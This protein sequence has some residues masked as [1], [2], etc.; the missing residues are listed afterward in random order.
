MTVSRIVVGVDGSD[1]SQ[2]ALAW[3]I[4]LASALG[5]EIVAVHSVGLLTRDGHGDRVPASSHREEIAEQFERDWCAPLDAHTGPNRRVL[6]DGEPVDVVLSVADDV[7][8]DMIV[9]GSRGVG[10]YPEQLLGSTSHQVAERSP[11]PVVIVPP[12]ARAAA[13]TGEESRS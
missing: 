8:A 9:L 5:A 13:V 3:A 6:R 7:E 4:D 10:G 12:V 1:N 11:R 2:R